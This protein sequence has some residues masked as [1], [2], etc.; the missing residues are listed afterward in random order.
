VG[1][2]TRRSDSLKAILDNI[3]THGVKPEDAYVFEVCLRALHLFAA[4]S[5]PLQAFACVSIWKHTLFSDQPMTRELFSFS[6]YKNGW[7]FTRADV[8]LKARCLSRPTA[9][10]SHLIRLSLLLAPLLFLSLGFGCVVV[11]DSVTVRM[12]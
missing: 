12:C 7:I 8:H 6:S 5:L 9:H 10:S 11:L 2:R 4:S 1:G 3:L